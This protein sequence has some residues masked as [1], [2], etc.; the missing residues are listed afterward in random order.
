MSEAYS[1]LQEIS[2]RF[3]GEDLALLAKYP[4]LCFTINSYELFKHHV[5]SRVKR[6]N[7][8]IA[9]TQEKSRIVIQSEECEEALHLY[10]TWKTI[11]HRVDLEAHEEIDRAIDLLAPHQRRALSIFYPD[12]KKDPDT[13]STFLCLPRVRVLFFIPCCGPCSGTSGHLPAGWPPAA[14][15]R[16]THRPR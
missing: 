10:P 14:G 9:I 7:P 5:F 4:D 2:K 6:Q 16:R 12:T 11:E 3:N 1:T 15:A 8:N 13:G